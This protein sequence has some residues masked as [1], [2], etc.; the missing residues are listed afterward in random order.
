MERIN[1]AVG[2]PGQGSSVAEIE[3]CAVWLKNQNPDLVNNRLGQIGE[4][5]H[6]IC[7]ERL[8]DPTKLTERFQNPL[9][10]VLAHPLTYLT[11]TVAFEVF[12]DA[13]PPEKY[14]VSR[15][16]GHSLGEYAAYEAA[17]ALTFEEGAGLVCNRGIIA[18]QICDNNPGALIR[19]IGQGIKNKVAQLTDPSKRI[20]LA[21]CNASD[22]IVVGCHEDQI[23]E[24]EQKAKEGGVRRIDRLGISGAF[25][26]PLFAEAAAKMS[27]IL[28][29]LNLRNA[30]I[31]IVMALDAQLVQSGELLKSYLPQSLVNPVRWDETFTKL[32]EGVDT[33]IEIGPGKSL[34][35]LAKR[36]QTRDIM[37]LNF[38]EG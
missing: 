6:D 30:T 31:P 15:V 38:G 18:Q 28:E 13:F 21:L 33:F 17:G 25:H 5:F 19:L 20:W 10:T 37:L 2:F 22:I 12:S 8:P 9:P 32:V 26:T 27:H 1:A 24:V 36:H 23:P 14:A 4:I 34:I 16:A 11:E 3:R 29:T 35:S 7:G